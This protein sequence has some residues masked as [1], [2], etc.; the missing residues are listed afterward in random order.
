MHMSHSTLLGIA[1][2]YLICTLLIA[3][4]VGFFKLVNNPRFRSSD[5]DVST[6]AGYL[7]DSMGHPLSSSSNQCPASDMDE[8]HIMVSQDPKTGSL[9]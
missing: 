4:Y 2:W 7:E 9:S 3:G 8:P 1:I 6:E 5:G